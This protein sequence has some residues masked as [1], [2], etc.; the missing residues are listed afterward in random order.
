MMHVPF[1]VNAPVPICSAAYTYYISLGIA[2][3]CHLHS[4]ITRNT[5]AKLSLILPPF[6]ALIFSTR[7]PKRH[8]QSQNHGKSTR[9][10][11]HHCKMVQNE[12]WRKISPQKTI[13]NLRHSVSI[14]LHGSLACVTQ[15]AKASVFS[16]GFNAFGQGVVF[17]FL[18]YKGSCLSDPCVST[19]N[20]LVWRY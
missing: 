11:Q 13:K 3:P 10:I 12:Q 8:V 5:H 20:G 6:T 18:P 9:A 17:L 16:I 19:A 14:A 2:F 15:K 1:A 7:N 4:T